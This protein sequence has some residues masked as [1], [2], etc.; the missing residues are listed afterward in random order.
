MISTFRLTN[1]RGGLGL[2]CTAA[3]LSLA[4][5]PLLRK[6][7]AGFVPRSAREIVSLIT[8][9]YGAEVDPTQLQPSLGVIAAALNR[10]DLARATTAA[11]LTRTPELSFAAAARLAHAEEALTKYDPAQPRDWHGRW[12]TGGAATPGSTAATTNPRRRATAQG[13]PFFVPVAFPVSDAETGGDD[14]TR[15]ST[16]L[17]Q[18]FERKY[19]DLGPVDFAKRVIEFGS[20]LEREGPNLSPAERDRALAEYSFLQNRLSFWL[21]YEYTPPTAHLNLI[22][23]ALTL[24]QGAVN[25]GF[26]RPGDMPQSMVDVAGAAWAFDNIPPR[27]G[28]TTTEPFPESEPVA[29]LA[30]A[31]EIEGFGGIV[32]NSEAKIVWW[33]GIQ[34]QGRD[35]WEAYIAENN[36]GARRLPAGSKGFDHFNDDTGEA[37]SGK[38]LNTLSVSYIKYPQKIFGNLR[39]YVD[40]A[41]DYQ[42]RTDLEPDPAKIQSRTIH[43]A[44]PEYTSP[45]QWRYLMGAIGYGREH[46]VSII[47]T[48]I[49]E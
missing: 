9:A 49:R 21:G 14:N 46:G 40:A 47:I 30:P 45:E 48:R 41:V 43:L 22:S 4:G 44:I 26:I 10:G 7:Q 31:K 36:P 18:A 19:D 1:E 8:A 17:E 35:G 15:D 39:K 6:T 29:P 12:T 33:R 3:G 5:V 25:G 34:A 24:Y 20:W 32:N 28:H 37:I 16:S 11:V 23:A 27:L 42:P 38:T 13:N 2:S